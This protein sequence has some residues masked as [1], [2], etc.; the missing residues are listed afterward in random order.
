MCQLCIKEGLFLP[1]LKHKKRIPIVTQS[2]TY[3]DDSV[4][5]LTSVE[6]NDPQSAVISDEVLKHPVENSILNLNSVQT[7]G[8]D[9]TD[10]I[11]ESKSN[12]KI[13][14]INEF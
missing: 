13:D 11:I 1:Q 10:I 5:S 4:T 3:V 2:I 14:K 6:N 9:G 12:L 7:S 8:T